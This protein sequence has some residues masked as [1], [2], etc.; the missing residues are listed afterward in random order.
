MLDSLPVELLQAVRPPGRARL[1]RGDDQP[2]A[3]WADDDGGED[4]RFGGAG[5][6]RG[7][8]LAVAAATGATR[9]PM[10]EAD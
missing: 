10:C 8:V 9:R 6:F 2:W 1:V 7:R 3:G 5:S 4:G